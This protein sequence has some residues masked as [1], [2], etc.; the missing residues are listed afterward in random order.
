MAFGLR[1]VLCSESSKCQTQVLE[2]P[3]KWCD[4]N[5][6]AC[7]SCYHG[8]VYCSEECRKEARLKQ[9]REAQARFRKTADGREYHAELEKE[10]RRQR[11]TGINPSEPTASTDIYRETSLRVANQGSRQP[12]TSATL[13]NMV[14]FAGLEGHFQTH[15][16][17]I[18][19]FC[20]K[21]G[22][23]VSQFQRRGY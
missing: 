23:I 17:G 9:G 4:T 20:G 18:C 6:Y 3:C 13:E 14:D 8:Q 19:Q 12:Q 11:K 22:A 1:Q 15:P 5:F 2:I 10:R 7:R 16:T 21:A